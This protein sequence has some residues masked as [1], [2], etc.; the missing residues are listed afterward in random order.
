MHVPP[1]HD[2]AMVHPPEDAK[3]PVVPES[4]E[5]Y[6]AMSGE[7]DRHPIGVPRN[8]GPRT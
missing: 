2:E 1:E 5:Y 4:D 6:D 7:L 8:R 3:K